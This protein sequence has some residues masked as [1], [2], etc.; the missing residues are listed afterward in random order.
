MRLFIN[1]DKVTDED[2]QKHLKDNNIEV[3]DY[4]LITEHLKE[5]V[6]A[7]KKIGYD[8]NQCNVQ[9]FELIKDSEPVTFSGIIEGIKA[10]KNPIEMQGMRN[11]N[12][13]NCASLV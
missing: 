9:L 3:F 1:P 8:E 11:A 6:A 4:N 13:K 7:K 10:V 2:V 12:I 5:L